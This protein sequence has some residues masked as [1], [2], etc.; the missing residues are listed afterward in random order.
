MMRW[1]VRLEARTEGG[2]AE[3]RE[4]SRVDRR[5]VAGTSAG[6]GLAVSEAKVGRG[7]LRAGRV[8]SQVVEQAAHSRIAPQRWVLP[9]L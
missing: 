2:V 4:G 6:M 1:T 7:E 3:A 9:A 8:Q 5:V